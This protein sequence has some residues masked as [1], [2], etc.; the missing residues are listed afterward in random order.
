[1]RRSYQERRANHLIVLP[2]RLT[3]KAVSTCPVI[4]SLSLLVIGLVLKLEGRC[5]MMFILMALVKRSLDEFA[6]NSILILKS[7]VRS[8]Q[9]QHLS[10][11][12][13]IIF[14]SIDLY[15]I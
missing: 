8:N 2:R 12:L 3:R 14:I 7:F 13:N 6:P 15:I 10:R 9:T 11:M 4:S 5:A 1:M